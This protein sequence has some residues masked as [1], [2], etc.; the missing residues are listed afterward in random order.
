MM[1]FSWEKDMAPHDDY[2]AFEKW[3]YKQIIFT[4]EGQEKTWINLGDSFFFGSK[5]LVEGV[6]ED[7]VREDL[8]GRALSSCFAIISKLCSRRSSSPAAI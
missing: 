8:E 1:S 5:Y 2:M 7:R 6:M 4:P 3:E